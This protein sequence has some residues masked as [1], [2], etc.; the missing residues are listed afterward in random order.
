MPAAL[1]HSTC[2]EHLTVALY[3]KG[4]EFNVLL[5]G[6]ESECS[7]ALACRMTK[8]GCL[9]WD[10]ILL[11]HHS[12]ACKRQRHRRV[13]CFRSCAVDQALCL[14]ARRICACK[15]GCKTA[16]HTA[17]PMPRLRMP[18]TADG[19]YQ[20]GHVGLKDS[21]GCSHGSAEVAAQT[22]QP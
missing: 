14:G 21:F 22:W 6:G 10:H 1:V 17:T 13:H 15:Q 8:S 5:A 12:C 11:N 3:L 16:W 7:T 20:D 9:H 19:G 4:R 2:L 18:E